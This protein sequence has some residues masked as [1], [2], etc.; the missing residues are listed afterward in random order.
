[1]E[2]ERIMLNTSEWWLAGSRTE[3]LR[4]LSRIAQMSAAALLHN[5]LDCEW[6]GRLVLSTASW[7]RRRW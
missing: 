6:L 3:E 7:G 1:M 2:S 4:T 5:T